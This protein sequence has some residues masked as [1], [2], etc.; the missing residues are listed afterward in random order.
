MYQLSQDTLHAFSPFSLDIPSL[1]PYFQP[2][3]VHKPP[4]LNTP[5]RAP[6]FGKGDLIEQ[7]VS[8]R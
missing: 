5:F 4:I 3:L 6:G 8:R 1:Q 7:R 2:R